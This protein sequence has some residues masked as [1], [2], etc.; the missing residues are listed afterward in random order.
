[1]LRIVIQKITRIAFYFLVVQM[2]EYAQRR[3]G[4]CLKPPQPTSNLPPGDCARCFTW[5][6]Q[7]RIL[8]TLFIFNIY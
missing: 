2:I 4:V 8:T 1:M 6:M 5:A 7:Y 3:K